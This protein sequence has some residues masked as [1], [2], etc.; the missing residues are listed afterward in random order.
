[1]SSSP[2]TSTPTSLSASRTANPLVSSAP[3][4]S[5]S[6]SSDPA[7]SPTS[8]PA[9]KSAST[10]TSTSTSA[11]MS[12][13]PTSTSHT[14][15]HTASASS[16]NTP[17]STSTPK[18][19]ST[20]MSTT[21]TTT[22]STTTSSPPTSSST[23]SKTT[24]SNTTSTPPISTHSTSH[25]PS[26]THSSTAPTSS[27]QSVSPSSTHSSTPDPSS[28]STTPSRTQASTSTSP[29]STLKSTHFVT[30]TNSLGET[31]TSAPA[32]VTQII[33]STASNGVLVT[34]TSVVANPTLSP[35]DRPSG[36]TFFKNTGAVAGV[37]VLVGLSV[38][39]ICLWIFFAI[40]R[41]RRTQKL[42]R[43]SA[44]SASLAAA[45]FK[46]TDLE[47]DV[48]FGRHSRNT[49]ADL[50]MAQRST[51]GFGRSDNGDLF[52][53]FAGYATASHGARGGAREGGYLPAAPASPTLPFLGMNAYLDQG[54]L[55]D[56]ED[57][58]RDRRIS[59]TGHTSAASY[60]P[61]LAYATAA[62][63][64]SLEHDDDN[65]PPTPPPRNPLRILHGS[66][67]GSP[68]GT[69]TFDF[70]QAT[71]DIRLSDHDRVSSEYSD[72]SADHDDRLNPGLMRRTRAGS[73]GDSINDL[74]D[75]EDYSRPVLAVRNMTTLTDAS[76][77]VHSHS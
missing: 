53:P 62:P 69:P 5:T 56:H 70:S 8:S 22:T 27:S 73:T 30:T 75:D 57:G 60:E 28:S 32:V 68:S 45:G 21:T 38:A 71:P 14:P 13:T 76:S 65:R 39:G 1:M 55:S 35:D 33:T 59:G 15:S 37:F 46:R 26:T 64:P 47:D 61:L 29:S 74:R 10:S 66:Q 3:S 51:S 43:D 24:S 25:P 67:P 7:E 40:R 42:E 11:S 4:T 77:S 54:R 72:E 19:S 52:D 31:T 34:K 50:E 44:V 36:S 17:T 16:S 23:S 6:A 49:L 48:D 41:R 2:E 20:T 63:S 12:S 58:G 18:S 9:S